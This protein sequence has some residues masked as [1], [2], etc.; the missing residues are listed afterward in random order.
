MG[1]GR[2]SSTHS[3]GQLVRSSGCPC[4][5]VHRGIAVCG[6]Q[7]LCRESKPCGCRE[8][9]GRKTCAEDQGTSDCSKGTIC[10]AKYRS[11]HQLADGS[12]RTKRCVISAR[13][14][15]QKANS[16]KP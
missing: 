7:A 14:R 5:R 15:R 4:E 11:R 16:I 10:G 1:R 2:T 9:A 6:G 3:F 12:G 13:S 8:L